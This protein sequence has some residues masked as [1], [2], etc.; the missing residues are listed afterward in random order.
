[1]KKINIGIQGGRSSYNDVAIKRH[2][3]SFSLDEINIHY[4]FSSDKVIEQLIDGSIRYGQIAIKN[5]VGGL[6]S[7]SM[8]AIAK[9]LSQ[10]YEIRALEHYRLFPKHCLMINR[11]SDISKIERI[12]SHSQ[13]LA[14]CQKNLH[15]HYPHIERIA[16]EQEYSDPSKIAEAISNQTLELDVATLSNP[17]IAD[18]YDLQVVSGELQD[19]EENSTL[20]LLFEIID[21]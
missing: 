7:E 5:S 9:L 12:I 16:G 10:G 3:Q 20:F 19:S 13:A 14:Q 15:N 18:T 21:C 17:E 8:D 2:M 6:V 4:L 11:T 1:M